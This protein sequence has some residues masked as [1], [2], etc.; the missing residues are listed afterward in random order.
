MKTEIR[1]VDV[2]FYSILK[3][4][5]VTFLLL[6]LYFIKDIV[7]IV[8]VAVLLALTVDPMVD[9]LKRKYALPRMAGAGAIFTVTLGL[10]LAIIYVIVPPLA[11]QISQL[12]E[13]L[14][15]F[16]Q[17]NNW[18]ML[19]QS[20]GNMGLRPDDL[21][22]VI[23]QLSGGIKSGGE[24]LVSGAMGILGGILSAI[25][26]IVMTFYLVLEDD[27][28]EKFIRALVPDAEQA[29]A[30]RVAAK[31]EKKLGQ[32]LLGQ[33]TLG[34]IVGLLSLA[35]LYIL[36][37]P[38][39]TVLALLAGVL[40]LV[41]YI[42]P[43]LSAIPAVLIAFSVSPTL[44]FFTLVLYFLIQQFENHVIVPKVM[45]KS[46]GLHPIIII[47]AALLGGK[48]AGVA[49][50]ILAVPVATIIAIMLEDFRE[51]PY[52]SHKSPA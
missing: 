17:K 40:E 2:S 31:I 19:L 52:H 39:P 38:Y 30:L 47:I 44:A 8:L 23:G 29:R 3:F 11:Q 14:P 28:V 7:L 21:Q 4:F 37:V 22:N 13:A 34:V 50:M 36:G 24:T 25:L 6:F 48:L 27:G 33:L 35:G 46:V 12:S 5:G 49:G 32:W 16:F 26:V 10:L 15:S 18:E 20:G 51:H 9:S 43:A 41:P 1:N 45:S 42:G